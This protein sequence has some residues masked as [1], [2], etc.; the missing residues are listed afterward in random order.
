MLRNRNFLLLWSA[1][2]I[3]GAG[4]TF[5]FIALTVTIDNL[6]PNQ[7]E[8]ARAL[9]LVLIA[10]ALPQLLLGLFAGTL[11]DRWDRRWV[12]IASDVGRAIL[13]P[14][15]TLLDSPADL[16]WV[17]ALGFGISTFSAF[18]VPARTAIMPNLVVEDE[19]MS[20][21]GWM[22][23]GYTIARLIG[24]ALGGL[25]VGGLGSDIAF[26]IDAGS[27]FLSALLLVGISGVI[28][29]AIREPI[30][31][32][33]EAP[34]V[35]DSGL[36]SRAV[37]EQRGTRSTWED[38][39]EGVRYVLRSRLLQGIMLG[40]GVVML[41][42]GAVQV[43]FVPMLRRIH[44]ATP[45]GVGVIMTVQGGAMLASGLLIG[46]WGRRMP[47]R[48]MSVVSLIIY[49]ASVSLFGLSPS[50]WVALAIM[51]LIGLS[52]PPI[53]AGLQTLMQR[54]VP[55]AMLGRAEAVA[56]MAVATAG[57]VSMAM[58]GWLGD[59]LGLRGTFLLGGGVMI[60]GGLA[61]GTLLQGVRVGAPRS[62]GERRRRAELDG[63]SP[64]RTGSG[65][66]SE[67][68]P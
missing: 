57:L 46:A 16:P 18:F 50:Y 26:L 27:F 47:S 19:L 12:M 8:S 10:F 58:A 35:L 31:Q 21:N 49:G 64:D 32:E 33:V 6:F 68:G 2:L 1:Q 39:V 25:V 56:D 43:L 61:M 34:G 7:G 55:R 52:V 24:P 40:F 4:D 48:L 63:K 67:S 20:A 36:M 15:L 44:D 53:N 41:G 38:L 51:P 3:S 13:V 23:L 5:T 37:P 28:T 11:V 54:G 17:I 14:F 30:V 29:R 60:F 62:A 22:E 66:T 65:S 45:T 42:N 59:Q 9:G